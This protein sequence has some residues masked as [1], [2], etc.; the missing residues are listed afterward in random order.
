MRFA[1]SPG[2]ERSRSSKL[3]DSSRSILEERLRAR[4][5]GVASEEIDRYP[6]L[7]LW[8]RDRTDRWR[9][10]ILELDERMAADSAVLDREFGCGVVSGLL[11]APGDSHRGGRSV[12]IVELGDRKRIVYKPRPMAVDLHFQE[13]IRWVNQQGLWPALRPIRILDRGDYGWSELI[14]PEECGSEKN[15]EDFYLRLGALLALFHALGSSDIHQ[16]NL[17]AAGAHPVVVDLE[18]ILQPRSGH[19]KATVLQS[20]LLPRDLTAAD[21][22][23][24]DVSGIGGEGENRPVLRGEKVDFRRYAD[25]VA[26]GFS[27]AYWLLER[28]RQELLSP[29]GPLSWFE[30]DEV[31]TI[32][33]PSQV[34]ARAIEQAFQPLF[35]RDP[36]KRRPLF[37]LVWA[38]A[39][40]DPKRKLVL[41]SEI[42]DL[43]RA[44]IPL[45]ST[46]AGSLDLRDGH[47]RTI[48][49]FWTCSALDHGRQRVASLSRSDLET[50]LGLL[51]SSLAP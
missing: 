35:L 41:A 1:G 50:Q 3:F 13:L 24:V 20:G 30:R 38:A 12:M 16:E 10:F 51:R 31:R 8:L 34:Y 37:E 45:L 46:G 22:T 18:T 26:E 47:G 36:A 19:G 14:E 17:I 44:D 7:A 5:G 43:L 39:E 2:V 21:G 49:G 4:T 29:G 25:A 27:H 33:R 40:A 9:A 28:R 23:S 11:D 42:D 32:L 48:P 15:V 6:A